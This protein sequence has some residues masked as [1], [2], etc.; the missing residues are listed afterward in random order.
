M[1]WSRTRSLRG[2]TRGSTVGGWSLLE[3]SRDMWAFLIATAIPPTLSRVRSSTI[4][5][6][7]CGNRGA[8][9]ER[10]MDCWNKA[11][12]PSRVLLF[13]C[14]EVSQAATTHCANCCWS[15]F[16]SAKRGSGWRQQDRR[17]ERCFHRP[18]HTFF[19]GA[20]APCVLISASSFESHLDDEPKQCI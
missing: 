2:E 13:L 3:I 11:P 18:F 12:G 20:R 5:K 15:V 1:Q 16:T 7:F 14:Q 9:D 17:L 4:T 19:S 10:K 6:M 8:F